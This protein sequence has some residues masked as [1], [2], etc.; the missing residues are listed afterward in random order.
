MEARGMAVMYI[1]QQKNYF[2]IIK[3]RKT[4]GERMAI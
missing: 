2:N 3:F 4:A 1:N